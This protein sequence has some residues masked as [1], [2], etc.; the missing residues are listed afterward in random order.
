MC[1][2]YNIARVKLAKTYFTDF[3]DSRLISLRAEKVV[4]LIQFVLNTKVSHLA[5]IYVFIRHEMVAHERSDA[6]IVNLFL[7]KV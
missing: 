3:W 2:E 5:F 6:R 1:V 4:Y 7:E